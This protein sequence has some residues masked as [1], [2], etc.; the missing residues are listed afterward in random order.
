MSVTGSLSYLDDPRCTCRPSRKQLE[1]F[2]GEPFLVELPGRRSY[3]EPRVT[4]EADKIGFWLDATPDVFLGRRG[5]GPLIVCPD[6]S[7]LIWMVNEMERMEEK[8]GLAFSPQIGG[9][10]TDPVDA[11]ADLLHLWQ[12]RDIRFFVSDHYLSDGKLTPERLTVRQGVVRE[13]SLDFTMR[14]GFETVID[15]IHDLGDDE[16]AQFLSP[17]CPVHPST[18]RNYTPTPARWPHTKDRALLADALNSGCHVFLTL[19]KGVLSCAPAFARSGLSIMTP[20]ELLARLDRDGQLDARP[21]W[22]IDLDVI[23]RFYGIAVAVEDT[24]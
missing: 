3:T 23:G 14:G 13:F 16:D 1:L 21:E 17:G 15:E 10:W 19:D 18:Q 11:I 9:N 20:G 2:D 5:D 7:V 24:V 12:F 22:P 8:I 6:T 4:G